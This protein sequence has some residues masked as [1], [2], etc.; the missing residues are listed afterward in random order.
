VVQSGEECDVINATWC[1]QPGERDADGNLIQCQIKGLTIPGDNPITDLWMTIPTLSNT[2]LGYTWLDGVPG[3]IRFQDN[4]MVLGLNTRA[5][6]LADTV[7]FGIKTWYQIPLIIEADKLVCLKSDGVTL[8]NNNLCTRFGDLV[9]PGPMR[10]TPPGSSTGYIVMGRWYYQIRQLDGSYVQVFASNP[11]NIDLFKGA[12]TYSTTNGN[13]RLSE[14]F[15][16]RQMGADDRLSLYNISMSSGQPIDL[17]SLDVRMSAAMVGGASSTVNRKIET[18]I[19]S[20]SLVNSFLSGFTAYTTTTPTSTTNGGGSATANINLNIS[21]SGINKTVRTLADLETLA[22]NG[23]KNILALKNG[24][25]TIECDSSTFPPRTALDLTG[26]RTVI[27]ENGNL[28]LKC[29]NG[30]LSSDAVSSWAFI[31]KG[32]DIQVATGMTNM[33]GVY[34][35]IPNGATGGNFTPIG[36]TTTNILRLNGSMYGNAKP[37]FDS[38]LY[39]RGTNAYDILTTGVIIS[40]SNRALANP[41]PLLSQY[42]NNYTVVRV[43]K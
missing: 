9:P 5:F 14:A 31:V 34:V 6:T 33:A 17:V 18:Y 39:V 23:N 42:L 25:L 12:N 1:G 35:A 4:R 40:Y 11:N 13:M 27:V 32:G 36:G 41:P 2:R 26:I 3:K 24:N 29:N 15:Y 37:L 22:V 28:I 43:V 20:S 16:A 21:V 10:F 8:N 30:Y 7:G 38:R 19:N